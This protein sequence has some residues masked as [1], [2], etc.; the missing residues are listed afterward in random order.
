M[1]KFSNALRLLLDINILALEEW[2][3][4]ITDIQI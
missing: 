4:K 3:E 1:F 2:A